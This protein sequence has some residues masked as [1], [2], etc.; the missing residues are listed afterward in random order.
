MSSLT[1]IYTLHLSPNSLVA[2]TVLLACANIGLSFA[3]A[4]LAKDTTTEEGNLVDSE[5]KEALGTQTTAMHITVIKP[6]EEQQSRRE[7]ECDDQTDVTCDIGEDYAVDLVS[8]AKICNECTDT[9]F[10]LDYDVTGTVR[11][12]RIMCPAGMDFTEENIN[13]G[14]GKKCCIA[15]IGTGIEIKYVEDEDICTLTGDALTSDENGPCDEDKDC[16]TGLVCD[17]ANE[18]CV[19]CNNDDDCDTG[20]LCGPY[21]RPANKCHLECTEDTHCDDTN[22]CTTDT[23]SDNT[24]S[25]VAV[26]EG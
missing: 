21:G 20:L 2:L 1:L 5:T 24:C 4:F 17:L 12:S 15:K 10:T 25:N 7:Q 22:E 18:K 19:E 9:T 11:R 23:C 3:A 8:C 6:S 16:D 14:Q 26:D 13:C